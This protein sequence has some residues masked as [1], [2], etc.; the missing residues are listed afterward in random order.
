MGP[1]KPAERGERYDDA[2]G[3]QYLNARYYDPRL[4]MFIQPDWWEVT[5]KGVGTNRYSYSFNDPVNMSDPKGNQTW[6]DPIPGPVWQD[7]VGVVGVIGIGGIAGGIVM[8]GRPGALVDLPPID[9]RPPPLDPTKV[10]SNPEQS[11]VGLQGLAPKSGSIVFSEPTEDDENLPKPGDLVVKDGK[12]YE[13]DKDGELQEKDTDIDGL[14]GELGVPSEH[15]PRRPGVGP[16]WPGTQGSPDGG[17]NSPHNRTT[18]REIIARIG[19]AIADALNG[20][21]G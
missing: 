20:S 12:I 14:R 15:N 5:K 17:P 13:V 21:D 18:L 7:N 1:R 4:G 19:R 3:L 6:F 16:D 11:P 10:I 2:S 9:Q 8:G